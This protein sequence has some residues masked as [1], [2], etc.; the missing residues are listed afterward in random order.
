MTAIDRGSNSR[1]MARLSARCSRPS[2]ES[3]NSSVS[4]SAKSS[5]TTPLS[6]RRCIG[7]PAR[8]T[9]PASAVVG[10]HIG[11]EPGDAVAA[12]DGRQVLE[13]QRG[14]ALALVRVVDHERDLG[15]VTPGPPFVARPPAEFAVDLDDQRDAVDEVDVGEM[16]E[17]G[18]A[19]VGLG[20][21]NRRYRFSRGW[22]SW[23][24]SE[25]R[26]IIDRIGRT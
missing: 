17:V 15:I 22:R 6:K 5:S 13:Q 19:Q 1:A 8:R 12:S 25:R 4:T 14:D 20:E 9:P 3:T 7:Q 16:A 21:K 2:T 11:S 26:G 23:K 18:V 10:E 24:A